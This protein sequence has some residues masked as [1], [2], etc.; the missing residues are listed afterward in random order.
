MLALSARIAAE[1]LLTPSH[2]QFRPPRGAAGTCTRGITALQSSSP[3]VQ[4]RMSAWSP[5]RSV[6]GRRRIIW[7]CPKI[8]SRSL[9]YGP[10]VQSEQCESKGQLRR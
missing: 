9:S 4:W 1:L 2:N 5:A 3:A 8:I 10:F 6:G 7:S